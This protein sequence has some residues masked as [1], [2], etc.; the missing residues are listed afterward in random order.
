MQ[1]NDRRRP[2]YGDG[3]IRHL[4]R[5]SYRGRVRLPSVPMIV[6]ATGVACVNARASRRG[7]LRQDERAT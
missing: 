1:R 5:A 7:A 4:Y 6:T 2:R 3:G